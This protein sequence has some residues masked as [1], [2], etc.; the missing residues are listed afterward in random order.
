M[1]G[2]VAGI[3]EIT[4]GNTRDGLIRSIIQKYY[5]GL[6]YTT[7][8]PCDGSF[9]GEWS[10]ETQT[11][12]FTTECDEL[13]DEEMAYVVIHELAHAVSGGIGHNDRFYAVLTAFVKSE[14]ISWETAFRIEEIVP[15]LWKP[16]DPAP[17]RLLTQ[18]RR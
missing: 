14:G 15:L 1:N 6:S 5:P 2:T 13:N 10:E 17:K 7:D 8:V 3:A 4:I 12:I 9:R 18:R 16:Y 11:L